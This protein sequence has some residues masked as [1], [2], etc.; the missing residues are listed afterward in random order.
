MCNQY[1]AHKVHFYN[2]FARYDV[3]IIWRHP[4]VMNEMNFPTIKYIGA[5]AY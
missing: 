2:V 5:R 3:I 1:K 4:T